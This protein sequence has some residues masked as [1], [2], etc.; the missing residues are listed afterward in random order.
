MK[1]LYSLSHQADEKKSTFTHF[2]QMPATKCGLKIDKSV[3]ESGFCLSFFQSFLIITN[4]RI[5]GALCHVMPIKHGEILNT[6]ICIYLRKGVKY[7]TFPREKKRE[8]E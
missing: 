7:R 1:F 6:V 2:T 8:I 3:N 5:D 4:A